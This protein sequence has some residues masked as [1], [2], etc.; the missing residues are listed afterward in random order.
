MKKNYVLII[1]TIFLLILISISFIVLIK[2]PTVTY[3]YTKYVGV[4]KTYEEGYQQGLW[5]GFNG[6]I[7]YLD[8]KGVI[9]DTININISE[10]SK[11]D[12]ILHSIK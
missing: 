7:K 3:T 10:I 2:T 11:I 5:D 9:K 1:G 12:S 4:P 8:M 6:T